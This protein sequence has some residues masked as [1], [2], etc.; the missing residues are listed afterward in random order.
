MTSVERV[1]RVVETRIKVAR[2]WFGL[3]TLDD[4]YRFVLAA[5][6]VRALQAD[7]VSHELARDLVQRISTALASGDHV[8]LRDLK[9]QLGAD[10]YEEIVALLEV[11]RG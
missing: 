6:E 1:R 2:Q 4:V 5:P 9:T 7:D 3:R 10:T 8:E 11:E